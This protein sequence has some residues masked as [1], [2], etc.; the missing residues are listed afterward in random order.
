MSI[1]KLNTLNIF[2]PALL[3]MGAA[4]PA[5]AEDAALP[6]EI[7][8]TDTKLHYS[9]RFD[10]RDAKGPR[11]SWSACSVALKFKGAAANVKLNETGGNRFQVVVD[12]KP[13]NVLAPAKG[14]GVYALAANLPDGE[15]TVEL[16]KRTEPNV[17]ITQILG[18]QLS[19]GGTLL[20]LTPSKRRIEVIGDSIS[21]G[22]GNEGKDQNEHFK[23][24]T[25]NAYMTYGAIAARELNADY[26]CAAWSGRK[27]WPNFT[28]PEIYDFALPT[29]KASTWD[30]TQQVPDVVLI[31]LAT[32]DFGK[33]NPDETKWC[34]AYKTFILHIR[35]NYP[36]AAIYCASGSMM[37]D[38]WP[39]DQKALSTLHRY[40]NSILEDL[41]KSGETN[42]RFIAF[43]PQDQKNG[44]GSDWHP[45]I[46]TH[47]IMAAK[48]VAAIKKDLGW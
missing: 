45:S 4:F 24:E 14:S 12:G 7:A 32:N 46:K 21:C 8:A 6:V 42:V 48:F 2:A 36:K 44:L 11:C 23:A 43:D 9:G 13:S 17:G 37:S 41:K 30:F 47:E 35:K 18:F 31:N 3:L 26:V 38:G 19:A 16:V 5:L 34:D 39:K 28:V 1:R 20:E 33:G 10:T 40:L 27:M 25:E 22:Y 15:H 29:D